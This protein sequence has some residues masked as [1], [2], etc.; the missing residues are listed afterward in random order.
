M[1]EA[2]ISTGKLTA[3]FSPQFTAKSD[4]YCWIFAHWVFWFSKWCDNIA[5]VL[6]SNLHLH[7]LQYIAPWVPPLHK[8][9]NT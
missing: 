4:V 7:K 5:I 2:V 3:I 1:Q 8:L 6:C 9:V